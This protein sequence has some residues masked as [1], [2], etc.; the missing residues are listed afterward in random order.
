MKIGQI[1]IAPGEKIPTHNHY[2]V[3]NNTISFKTGVCQLGIQYVPG[4][5]FYLNNSN[6]DICLGKTGIYELDLNN[7]GLI[8]T[9]TLQMTNNRL[10]FPQDITTYGEIFNQNDISCLIIDYV[11]E[12]G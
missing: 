4:Y 8:K 9:I 7:I 5:Q 3:N 12:E 11:M 10:P 1:K 2:T 6:W